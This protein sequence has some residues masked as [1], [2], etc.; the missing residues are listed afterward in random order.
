MEKYVIYIVLKYLAYE[1]PN[2]FKDKEVT[3]QLLILVPTPI[4]WGP[5]DGAAGGGLL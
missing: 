3:A 1:F 5:R 2:I 4:D